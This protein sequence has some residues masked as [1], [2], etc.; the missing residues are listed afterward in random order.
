MRPEQLYYEDVAEGDAGPR[1]TRGPL[2]TLHLVRWAAAIEGWHRINY[3]Q[4]FAVEHD[5]LP[6]VVVNGSFK[7][8]LLT[9]MLVHW[10]GHEGWLVR[11]QCRFRRMSVADD[12]LT[13]WGTVTSTAQRDD[14]GLVWLDIGIVDQAGVETAPGV[15]IGA[16]PLRA[17]P[18][19]PYP[20]PEGVV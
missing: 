4:R 19:L 16:L 2:T 12:T 9:Q 20:F 18:A 15:A 3:D 10:L 6:G 11:M 8:Q 5:G 7:R 13:A 17:G 14:F 1:M